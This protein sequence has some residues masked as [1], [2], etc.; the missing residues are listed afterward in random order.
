MVLPMGPGTCLS[1]ECT[2]QA[3]LARG[4]AVGALVICIVYL[5]MFI[6]L[7][8]KRH[9]VSWSRKKAIGAVVGM[10]AAAAMYASRVQIAAFIIS[11]IG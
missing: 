10:A 4:I 1:L 2:G 7:L 11:H 5:A 6:L 9:T 3:S 8:R